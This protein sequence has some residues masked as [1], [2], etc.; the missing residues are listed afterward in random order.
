MPKSTQAQS[1]ECPPGAH[2]AAETWMERWNALP[3]AWF[4]AVI[5]VLAAGGSA[6]WRIGAVGVA[7]AF[8]YLTVSGWGRRDMR[9]CVNA[10]GDRFER[11]IVRAQ[12]TFLVSTGV[13]I[14]VT[15]GAHSP[16]LVTIVVAY[17]AAVTVLGDRRS[18]RLL[19][20]ATA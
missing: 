7:A 4:A 14:T 2:P 19:L 16:L 13:T 11:M 17:L 1:D 8:Q 12:S 9:R 3:L 5:A 6:P 15:G 20:G 10:D 18:T